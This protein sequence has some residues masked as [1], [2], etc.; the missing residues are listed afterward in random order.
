MNLIE[1]TLD[2]M[3]DVMLFF[4][5]LAFTYHSILEHLSKFSEKRHQAT[6][7]SVLGMRNPKTEQLIAF[8]ASWLHI[9]LRHSRT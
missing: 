6:E 8:L 9:K 5:F 3:L 1:L 2:V 7:Y 4:A